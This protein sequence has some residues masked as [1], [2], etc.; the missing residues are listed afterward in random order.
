MIYN[1]EISFSSLHSNMLS[2]LIKNTAYE[3]HCVKFNQDFEMDIERNKCVLHIQFDI[4]EGTISY[5][6]S[7]IKI[8]KKIPDIHIETVYTDTSP[9]IQLLYASS[10]YLTTIDKH[11]A[12]LYKTNRKKRIYSDDEYKIID[13]FKK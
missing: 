9:E 6:L 2:T 3:Y 1:I 11:I 8:I 13:L 12:F 4:K 10:Y 7:F 5:L